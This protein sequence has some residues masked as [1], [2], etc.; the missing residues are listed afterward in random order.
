MGTS[1]I[2]T[3]PDSGA[4]LTAAWGSAASTSAVSSFLF[5]DVAPSDPTPADFVV[6]ALSI[7][8]HLASYGDPKRRPKKAEATCK[9]LAR[10]YRRGIWLAQLVQEDDLDTLDDIARTARDA[11]PRALYSREREDLASHPHFAAYWLLSHAF[12]GHADELADALA[13]TEKTKHA[14]I[15][16]LRK[17]L[18]PVA[19]NAAALET[20][21]AKARPDWTEADLAR[22]RTWGD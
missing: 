21:F 5:N 2:A 1:V 4:Y 14:A 18:A 6:E 8:E 22:L 13:R 12:F 15:I 11:S 19:K 17:K 3:D 7:R 10:L 16:D 20:L 9:E